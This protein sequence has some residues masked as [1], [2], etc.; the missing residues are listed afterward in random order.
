M[1]ARLVAGFVLAML[2]VLSAAGAFVYWRVRIALDTGLDHSLR[3]QMTELQG[4]VDPDGNVLDDPAAATST[5]VQGH[6]LLRADGAVLAVGTTTATASLQHVGPLLTARDLRDV[7]THPITRNLGPL[8]PIT[9]HPRRVL[10]APRGRI[11]LVVVVPRGERDEALRELLGQLALAGLGALVVASL[12]GERLAKAALAPVERYRSQAATIAAGARGVRL[13][14]P[15]DRNDEVTRLGHTFNSVL[16]ALERALDTERGFTHAASHELRTPLTTLKGRL[17]LTRRRRRTPEDYERALDEMTTDITD[18]VHLADQLLMLG[19]A[20]DPT[21]S[22]H[23]HGPPGDLRDVAAAAAR[24]N[25]ARFSAPDEPIHVDATAGE[26]RQVIGNFVRNAAI[27]GSA[28]I[29]V[30]VRLSDRADLAIVTVHDGGPGLT[31]AFVAHAFERFRRGDD[32]QARPGSGLGLALVAAIAEGRAELRLC[33]NGH[34]H[35]HSSRYDFPCTHD[36]SG[37]TATIAM[38]IVSKRSEAHDPRT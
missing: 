27:H 11:I 31:P 35:T 3:E 21:C 37:T 8:L 2:V 38:A 14:V 33:S 5:A 7:R 13:D 24:D 17:Q 20:E 4:L 28:P 10:A 26:L 30:E 9:N 34:H 23:R 18:L 25:E 29:D 1:R 15:V 6:V 22:T 19:A 16:T 32:A 12:V 36:S